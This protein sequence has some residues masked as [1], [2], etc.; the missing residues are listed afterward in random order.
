MTDRHTYRT[1]FSFSPTQTQKLALTDNS[2][3][4]NSFQKQTKPHPVISY[5]G[6]DNPYSKQTV[7][8]GSKEK[9]AVT[10]KKVCSGSVWQG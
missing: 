5:G 1:T 7:A 9:T 10:K 4:I 3:N 6:A 8:Y 2:D